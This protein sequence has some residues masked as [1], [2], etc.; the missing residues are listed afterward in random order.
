MLK[1]RRLYTK[2]GFNLCFLIHDDVDPYSLHDLVPVGKYRQR[3]KMEEIGLLLA[4]EFENDP[5][6][7]A[8]KYEA[9][10]LSDVRFKVACVPK[11]I[12]ELLPEFELAIDIV[13]TS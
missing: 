9:F 6:G 7:S 8:D 1:Q 2:P 13:E 11:T 12:I 4:V 3:H 5:E 10:W